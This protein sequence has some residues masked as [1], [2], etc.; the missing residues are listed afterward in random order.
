MTKPS[1]FIMN[2]DYLSLTQKDNSEFTVIFAPESF[3]AGQGTTRTQDITVSSLKGAI[4]EVMISLNG[5]DYRVGSGI[6]LDS[7]SPFLTFYVYRVNP[8]TLRVRLWVYP[9]GSGSY[10][11]PLQ[12]L[13][14]HVSSFF[15][16]NV[17]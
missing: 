14:I 11:M 2:S 10:S 12:T 3:P 16:P 1:N 15:P 17:F 8:T 9:P 4:D 5:G 6:T 7:N 13:K